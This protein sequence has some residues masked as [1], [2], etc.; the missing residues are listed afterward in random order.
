MQGLLGQ[1]LEPS[2][3]LAGHLNR[4]LGCGACERHCPSN[5]A[6][7]DLINGLRILAPGLP[8]VRYRRWLAAILSATPAVAWIGALARPLTVLPEA[9]RTW[10]ARHVSLA[11]YLPGMTGPFPLRRDYP[12]LQPGAPVVAL[13]TGCLGRLWD[14]PALASAVRVLN[15]LGFGV[16]VPAGQACCG[17]LPRHQGDTRRAARKVAQ[18]RQA[19]RNAGVDAVLVLGSACAAELIEQ[20]WEP[21]GP[22]IEYLDHFLLSTHWPSLPALSAPCR[23]AIH[24]PC[25][26]VHRLNGRGLLPKLLGRLPGIEPVVLSDSGRCCG[27]AGLYALTQ[28]A[29]AAGLRQERLKAFKALNAQALVTGN[30]GCRLHLA[31]G[32]SG[33]GIPVNYPV[34]WLDRAL[35]SG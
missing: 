18:N 2:R 24:E 15:R 35:R 4:C 6:Y 13:F 25:S 32:L 34:E 8:G 10:L 33:T 29:V 9:A 22:R 7:D 14:A 30:I 1:A 12:A 11:G 19:F 17:L 20:C 5:V 28:P 31:A 16:T 23:V 21:R 26:L 3:R 27:G